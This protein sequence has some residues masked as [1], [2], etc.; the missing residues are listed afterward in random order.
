[1]DGKLVITRL[2]A[3]PGF[4]FAALYQNH[5][6][7]QL[8]PVQEHTKSRRGNIYLARVHGLVKNISAAFVDIGE[9]DLYFLNLEDAAKAFVIPPHD[10][11]L[12][13]GDALLVQV[14]KEATKAKKPMVRTELSIT[15]KYAVVFSTPGEVRYSAKLKPE[16]KA[17]IARVMGEKPF[18]WQVTVR[19]NAGSC[20]QPEQIRAE[21]EA[22]AEKLD[23]VIRNAPYRPPKTCMYQADNG[24]QAAINDI[25]D[26]LYTEAVTD[27]REIY[28]DRKRYFPLRPDCL[29]LYDDPLLPL[30]KLY[31]LEKEIKDA[32]SEKVY[33]KSGG[34]LIWQDTEALTAVD[35]NTG[36]FDRGKDREKTFLK[37]N[38]EAAAEIARQLQLRNTSG[39][40]LVDLINMKAAADEKAVLETFARE[41][42]K[43]V[44][45]PIIVDITKL[46]LLEMTRKKLTKPLKQLLTERE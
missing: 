2:P 3:Y 33:L 5:R 7:M 30:F 18:P 39:M 40:I 1:M 17:A 14:D 13:P 29:R 10:G 21:A 42:S 9:E 28:D 46:G 23:T 43:I 41:T 37:L 26:T 6:L 45:P 36:G 22:L 27:I 32:L 19:T 15:G 25:Y 20:P 4:I 44:N 12:R 24:L 34:Y 8:F 16:E 11:P 35:I 31:R 38:M